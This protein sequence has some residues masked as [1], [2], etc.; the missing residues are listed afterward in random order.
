MFGFLSVFAQ[1][2]NSSSLD[3]NQFFKFKDRA[4]NIGVGFINAESFAFNLFGA[5]G[6]GKPSPSLHTVYEIGLSDMISIGGFLDYYRVEAQAPISLNS[7][8]DEVSG[9]D[10]SDL[11]SIFS[12]LECLINPSLCDNES[13]VVKERVN[14][15]TL[16]GKLRIHRSFIPEL[17]TYASTYLGYS[18]NRR[19]TITESAVDAAAEQLGLGIRVPRII[20]YGSIGA[21]YFITDKLGV[22]GEYGIGNVHLLKLGV[23][24]RMN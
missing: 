19:K 12:V 21:R 6:S 14:V 7:I 2:S 5:S 24:L 22:Y 16:G 8:A 17:D 15:F 11:G 9:I 13:T 18:F 3:S 10:I 23:T 4:L 20:Y 1:N